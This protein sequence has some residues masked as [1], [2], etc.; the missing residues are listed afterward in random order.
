MVKYSVFKLTSH[1]LRTIKSRYEPRILPAQKKDPEVSPCPNSGGRV[2]IV[3]SSHQNWT[4]FGGACHNGLTLD[5]AGYTV[6]ATWPASG[7]DLY[8][9]SGVTIKNLNATGCGSG[10]SIRFSNNK[11]IGNTVSKCDYGIWLAGSSNNTVTDNTAS[12]NYFGIYL[13]DSTGNEIYNNN[14]MYNTTQ[15]YVSGGSDNKFNLDKPIGG[16]YWSDWTS[17]DAYGDGFVDDP[18]V[19]I[20]GQDNFHW[21]CQNGWVLVWMQEL[22]EQLM[23]LSLQQGIP[24]S[25]EAFISAVEAQK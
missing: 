16:N 4:S 18:Y 25:L 14:F 5:G 20:G 1:P 7:V 10:I 17:S 12:N 22:I 19:F 11:V 3:L 9:M 24:N 15:A 2:N 8:Q 13:Q 6:T 21:V 23:A